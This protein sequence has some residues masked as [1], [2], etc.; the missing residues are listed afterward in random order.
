LI[1]RGGADA[2]LS[3][4]F[5]VVIV[6]AAVGVALTVTA[7][8][9]E[10]AGASASA[11]WQ[12]AFGGWPE[13]AGTLE[14]TIPLALVALGWIVAFSASRI[15]IGFEGQIVVG[16]ICSAAVGLGINGLPL[17]IH[18][19]LAILAGVLGGA[20]YAGIA[21]WLWA[22]R[23][24]NEIISTLLLN[25][26]A[27]QLLSWVVRGPLQEPDHSN[28]ESSPI[29]ATARWPL[30]VGD[31]PLTWDVL[32]VP[33]AVLAAAFLLRKTIFGFW[34]RLTGA[35]ERAARYAGV[36]TTRVGVCALAV[37]GALA[38]LA[39]SSLILSGESGT[40]ADNFSANYGF[41]GI[42]VAL[43]A[44]NEPIAVIP[45]AVLFAALRQGGSFLATQVGVSPALVQII[46]GL[47]I[48]L[49][50]GSVFVRRAGR[51]QRL[52]TNGRSEA[53]HPVAAGS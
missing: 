48:V 3:F 29:A 44:R 23:G 14:K 52:Q 22:H 18:L 38:G 24:V 13:L 42:V 53:Q 6:L 36:R 45:A 4:A 43:L 46:Q 41:D 30:L 21:A 7:L 9:G 31:T 17:A 25:F 37:S 50:A 26:V 12:G 1:R 8:L 40:L 15:N 27:I 47:V 39:G 51:R 35:N 20:A 49:L 28:A 33:I 10:P 11:L 16:G 34:L 32:L 5:S 19:T 2:L